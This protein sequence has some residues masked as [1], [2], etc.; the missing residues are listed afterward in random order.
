MGKGKRNEKR[1]FNEDVHNMSKG[2]EGDEE[3]DNE[4]GELVSVF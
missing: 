3:R 1:T 2:E 4:V